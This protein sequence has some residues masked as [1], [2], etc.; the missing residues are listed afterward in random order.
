AKDRR[1]TGVVSRGDPR[2][3]LRSFPPGKPRTGPA[4]PR[5]SVCAPGQ[6]ASLEGRT[7]WKTVLGQERTRNQA[8]G[9]VLP[10]GKPLT[11]AAPPRRSV[12][13]PGQATSFS[14]RLDP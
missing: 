14:G 3:P 1:T 11:G 4:P 2:R 5:R 10:P 12:C 7:V 8:A 6:A 13:A 9:E